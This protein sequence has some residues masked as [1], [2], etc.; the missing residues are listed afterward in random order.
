MMTQEKRKRIRQRARE[1]VRRVAVYDDA[2][3][4]E[5]PERAGHWVQAWVLVEEPANDAVA[6]AETIKLD[7]AGA[8]TIPDIAEA[9]RRVMNK[10]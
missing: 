10:I 2:E 3:I 1:S 4:Y 6:N 8:Q 5:D 7:P 9:C